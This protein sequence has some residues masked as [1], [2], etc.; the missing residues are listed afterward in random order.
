MPDR[1]CDADLV[2]R[3]GAMLCCGERGHRVTI[4]K[5]FGYAAIVGLVAIGACLPYAAAAQVDCALGRAVAADLGDG[6]VMHTCLWQKS[7]TEF[8]RVG[9]LLLVRNGV[10][11][12]RAQTNRAGRLDG[13]YQSWDDGGSLTVRG[14]YRDGLKQG[15]WLVI[16]EQGRRTT[17]HYVDGRL[18]GR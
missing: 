16:D 10:P 5:R 7:E 18:L 17:L 3:G 6:V 12:L 8:V 14:E 4:P 11:I 13:R 1:N 2:C 15:A 9:P